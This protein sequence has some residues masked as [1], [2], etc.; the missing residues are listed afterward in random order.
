MKCIYWNARGIANQSSRLALKSFVKFI[1][2][3]LF[4]FFAEPW[5]SKDDFPASFWRKL[6]MKLF[7]VNDRFSLK[8]NLRCI[9]STNLEPAV[10]NVSDQYM[11]FSV[12]Y[13]NQNICIAALYA[14]TSYLLRRQ[15]WH[16]LNLLQRNYIFP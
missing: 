14:S 4:F 12:M 13:E 16:D 1:S 3:T 6:N 15:L 10:I 8:S 7:A 2:Q 11:A 5:I 9:C